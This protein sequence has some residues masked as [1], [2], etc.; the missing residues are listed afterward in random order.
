MQILGGVEHIFSLSWLVDT[1]CIHCSFNIINPLGNCLIAALIWSLFKRNSK[2]LKS[3]QSVNIFGSPL[4]LYVFMITVF[5]SSSMAPSVSFT[6]TFLSN[7]FVP[8][9]RRGRQ[10]L[11]CRIGD[12]TFFPGATNP[13][14][15]R[16]NKTQFQDFVLSIFLDAIIV[17][18]F[19]KLY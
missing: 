4:S 6:H 12:S 9:V 17:C 14:F 1:I 16:G 7:F 18:P 11:K 5:L 2:N 19:F 13:C 15:R 10:I 8:Q 3:F